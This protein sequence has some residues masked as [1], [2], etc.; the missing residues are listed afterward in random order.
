MKIT[1]TTVGNVLTIKEVSS[2]REITLR[3]TVTIRNKTKSVKLQ[4]RHIFLYMNFSI[5][6]IHPF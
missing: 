2:V 4:I 5:Y 6:G 3:Y 1:N